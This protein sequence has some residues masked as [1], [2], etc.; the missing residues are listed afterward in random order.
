MILFSEVKC[1]TLLVNKI[2]PGI[3]ARD[4]KMRSRVWRA[5]DDFFFLDEEFNCGKDWE[6][7]S[8]FIFEK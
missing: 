6:L 1:N 3:S 5:F 8:I 4:V 2:W 7:C